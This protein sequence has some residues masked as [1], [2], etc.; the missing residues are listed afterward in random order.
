MENPFP[1]GCTS[2]TD[3][4]SS[5]NVKSAATTVTGAAVPSKCTSKNG[6]THTAWNVWRYPTQS[7]SKTSQ[8]SMTHWHCMR[9]WWGNRRNRSLGLILMR[10]SKIIREI[11]WIRRPILIWR[12]KDWFSDFY[13][14]VN[15]MMKRLGG[16]TDHYGTSTYIY[17]FGLGF[18]CGGSL[19]K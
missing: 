6:V 13:S 9:N 5:T 2:F 19:G 1:I 8:L 12:N 14:D 17:S 7:T 3:W 11:C 16:D 15:I 18:Y 4:E 10:S